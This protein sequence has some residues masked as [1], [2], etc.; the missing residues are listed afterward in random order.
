MRCRLRLRVRP[1][2]ETDA[3]VGRHGDGWKVA[4]RAAPERGAANAAV[5]ALLAAALDLPRGAVRVVGGAATRSKVVEVDGL[6]SAEAAE[7]LERR[8]HVR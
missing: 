1:G 3:V 4:V 7:R 8:R 2:A 6:G 5:E